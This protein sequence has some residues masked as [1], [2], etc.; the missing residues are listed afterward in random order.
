MMSIHLYLDSSRWKKDMQKVAPTQKQEEKKKEA[1]IF[2]IFF[3]LFF[4]FFTYRDG[5]YLLMAW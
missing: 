2:F 3:I 1:F 4:F 5:G